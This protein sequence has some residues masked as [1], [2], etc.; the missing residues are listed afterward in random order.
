MQQLTKQIS[1]IERIDQLVRLHATGT[2]EEL[3][4][5][6]NISRAKLYRVIDVMKALEAPIVYD[7]SRQ[8][9]MYE[10][11]VRFKCGFYV[12]SLRENEAISING[13]T[14]V[15]SSTIAFLF[16]HHRISC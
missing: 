6:L 14:I 2:P 11:E 7:I 12:K 1:L 16:Y 5:R 10:D 9:F 4:T 15:M 13:G 3:A 8:S